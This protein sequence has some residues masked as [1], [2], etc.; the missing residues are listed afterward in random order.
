MA[1]AKDGGLLY[2]LENLQSLRTELWNTFSGALGEKGLR[3]LEEFLEKEAESLQ[4]LRSSTA[5]APARWSNRRELRKSLESIKAAVDAFLAVE[6]VNKPRFFLYEGGE[7]LYRGVTI[8]L[9][10]ADHAEHIPEKDGIIAVKPVWGREDFTALGHEYAHHVQWRKAPLLYEDSIL[11]EGHARGVERVVAEYFANK[12][13]DPLFLLGLVEE[14]YAELKSVYFSLCEEYG[15][16]A[17]E[18]CIRLPTAWDA[19]EERTRMETGLPSSYAIGNTL[20]YVSELLHGRD[21]YQ[22][23]VSSK[24]KEDF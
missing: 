15:E 17:A 21:I 3:C 11:C 10:D 6:Q 1:V 24:P 22:K 7:Q 5:V 13:K 12:E 14:T 4:R 20:F 16:R 23:A 18:G 9:S 2:Q 8:A 19:L